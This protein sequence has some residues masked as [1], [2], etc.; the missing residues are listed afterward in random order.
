MR[1]LKSNVFEIQLN[2]K[3]LNDL[4]LMSTM[5]KP[6]QSPKNQ[7]ESNSV[8]KNQDWNLRQKNC[9]I[10]YPEKPNQTADWETPNPMTI[11]ES[12]QTIL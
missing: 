12:K 11:E 3:S 6:N 4:C 5:K 8:D 2:P 1:N 10:F 7:I 9:L